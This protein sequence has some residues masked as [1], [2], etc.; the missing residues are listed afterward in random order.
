MLVDRA[1]S[2][3]LIEAISSSERIAVVFS[4]PTTH[5]T[6]QLK[7]RHA[8][9][10]EL[11]KRHLKLADE[12]AEAFVAQVCSIGFEESLVRALI[13]SDPASLVA[14]TFTPDEAFE[15]TPGPGAGN[16]MA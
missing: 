3:A 15:Q 5:R 10:L 16:R 13:W 14:V 2:P 4:E 6:I 12:Y 1:Q 8:E 7:S 9:V 11:R